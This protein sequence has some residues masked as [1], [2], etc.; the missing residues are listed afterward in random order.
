MGQMDR[1]SEDLGVVARLM[2]AY[3]LSNESVLDGKETSFILVAALVPQDVSSAFLY[4]S[5]R[6]VS[7]FLEWYECFSRAK[8]GM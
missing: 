6:F 7:I 4:I 5:R 3:L 1:S 8:L 2:Y